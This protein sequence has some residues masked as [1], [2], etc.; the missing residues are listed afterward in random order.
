MRKLILLAVLGAGLTLA[1]TTDAEANHRRGGWSGGWYS[2]YPHYGYGGYGHR[3]YYSPRYYGSYS[4]RYHGSYGH[5]SPWYYGGYGY[6]SYGYAYPRRGL[7][8]YLGSGGFS[9][10][11]QR[12]RW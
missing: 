6:R 4:P 9:V 7:S 10:G 1:G 2:S 5:Y 3:S 12:F 11:Y 8:L